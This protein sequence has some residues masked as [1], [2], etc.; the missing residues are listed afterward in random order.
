MKKTLVAKSNALNEGD[1]LIVHVDRDEVGIFRHRGALRAYSNYCLHSGGPACE[2]LIIARIEEHILPDKTSAGLFFSK[3]QTH[4]VC[5]WH[6]YEFD[7]QTGECI[8]NRK[9]KLRSYEVVEADG[10]IFILS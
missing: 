10:D 5:P 8:G 6:G 4:C 1:R 2:G 9:L 3:D 7:M